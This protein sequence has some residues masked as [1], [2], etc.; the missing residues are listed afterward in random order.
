MAAAKLAQCD[1]FIRTLH[2]GYDTVISSEQS[3]LSQGQQQLLTIARAALANPNVMILDEST[4]S[5]ETPLRNNGF[6]KHWLN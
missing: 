5:I 6:R 1:S 4:S 3:V 2:D